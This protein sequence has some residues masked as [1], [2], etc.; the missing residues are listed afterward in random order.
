MYDANVPLLEVMNVLGI[1]IDRVKDS[2]SMAAPNGWGGDWAPKKLVISAH[3]TCFNIAK[4]VNYI[5]P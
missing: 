2:L 1:V 4:T 5:T 3:V